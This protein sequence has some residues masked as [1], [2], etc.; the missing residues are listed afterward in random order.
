MIGNIW[1]N[2]AL[3]E[4]FCNVHNSFMNISYTV[5]VKNK[6]YIIGGIYHA[7]T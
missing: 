4:N 7:Y 1:E 5:F 6:I 3:C 2:G